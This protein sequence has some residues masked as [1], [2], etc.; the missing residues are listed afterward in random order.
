MRQLTV[1]DTAR[2]LSKQTGAT[3]APHVITNLFYKRHL[4]DEACPVIG[5]MRL[6]PESYLPTIEAVLRDRGF[7]SAEAEATV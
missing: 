5:R 1:S 6:I 4:D 3:V 7:I 2:E